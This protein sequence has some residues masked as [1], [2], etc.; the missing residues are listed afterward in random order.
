MFYVQLHTYI[1]VYIYI[2]IYHA[3]FIL[4]VQTNVKITTNGVTFMLKF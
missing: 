2:H 4:F 1:Y 3:K